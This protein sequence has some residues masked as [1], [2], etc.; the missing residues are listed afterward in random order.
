[1]LATQAWAQTTFFEVDGLTFTVISG[2]N[3]V[4]VEKGSTSPTNELSIP[5]SVEND[6]IPYMVVSIGERAFY[7][8]SGLT[9]V[10]IPNSVR[11]IG[12]E[13]F[14]N[15]SGLT[16]ITIPNSITSIGNYDYVSNV[17]KG[18][19]KL[20]E[21]NVENDNTNY[22]SE[23]GVLFNKDK[24]TLICCPAGKTGTYTIP[25]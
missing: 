14:V 6:G 9:S 23:E 22:S 11:I 13:A 7:N 17:F 1:M 8:C 21:I 5:S 12:D 24:T 3:T 19:S 16:S 2:I 15:C 20:A 18:C 25:N 10:S 4:S